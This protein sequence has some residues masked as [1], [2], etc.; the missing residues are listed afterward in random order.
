MEVEYERPKDHIALIRLNRPEKMNAFSKSLER[1]LLA[2]LDKACADEDVR[3]VMFAGSGR[4]FS[5]GWDLGETDLTDPEHHPLSARAGRHTWLEIVRMLRRPDKLFIAA[6]H[7]FAAGQGVELCIASDLVVCDESARFYFAET[8]VGFAM[9]S[10]TAKLLP[11]IVGLANARRLALLGQTIDGRE[12]HRI[13]LA[14]E[15]APP[16]GHEAAALRLAE[17]ALKGAPLAIAAQKQLLDGALAMSLDAVQDFE[18]QTSF[19]LTLTEDH[20]EAKRAFAAKRQ[21]VFRGR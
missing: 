21:P 19:R 16:G 7:G 13:G 15:L 14:V 10:G 5:G 17:E 12:A 6:V 20:Q 1:A 11:L 8:R 4:S 18:V 9:T 3:V 2:A